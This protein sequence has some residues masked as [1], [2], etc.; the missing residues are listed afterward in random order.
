MV[1]EIARTCISKQKQEA[2]RKN[3]TNMALYSIVL[4][5][6]TQNENSDKEAGKRSTRLYWPNLECRRAPL[7]CSGPYTAGMV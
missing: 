7:I 4:K 5:M 2:G 6:K 3:N 1:T